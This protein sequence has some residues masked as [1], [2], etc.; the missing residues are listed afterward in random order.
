MPADKFLRQR[1]VRSRSR[2][3]GIVLENG[4]A[5]AGRFA[6]TN[7]PRDDRFVNAFAEVS[8]NIGDHLRAQVRA[9]V[10][11]GHDNATDLEPVVRAGVADL[12]DDPDYLYQALQREV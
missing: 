9:A 1:P 4:F 6:Q 12:F 2:P 10:E 5:E 3:A 11:H 8:A 7:G